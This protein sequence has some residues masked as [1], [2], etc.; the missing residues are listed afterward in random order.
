[1]ARHNDIGQWGENVAREYLITKGYTV[2]DS[3]VHVG[4]K[5][6]DIVATKGNRII[7][8]EVKTRSDNFIDPA[9]AIDL[10][11]QNRIVRAAN[12]FIQSHDLPYEAQFDVIIIVGTP[13]KGYTLE[14][15]PDAF[16]PSLRGAR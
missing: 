16:F 7:F 12:A 4:H 3:N 14:H 2:A 15:I 9:E 13:E 5:E 11:K 6:L 1:M 10:K 8:I